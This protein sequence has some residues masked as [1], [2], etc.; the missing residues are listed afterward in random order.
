MQTALF[1]EIFDLPVLPNDD[2]L[3]YGLGTLRQQNL[4]DSR[5]KFPHLPQIAIWID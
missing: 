2:L 1:G 3:E 4:L 5:R